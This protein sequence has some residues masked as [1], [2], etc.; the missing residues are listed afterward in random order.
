VCSSDLND[1]S[2]WV[3]PGRVANVK[4]APTSLGM[5]T[6][7]VVMRVVIFEAIAVTCVTYSPG[8]T[9]IVWVG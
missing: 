1:I 9:M 7:R 6:A 2:I 3:T 8:R 4:P 5:L